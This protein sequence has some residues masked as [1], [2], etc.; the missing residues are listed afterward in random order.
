[1]EEKKLNEQLVAMYNLGFKDGL[2]DRTNNFNGDL[3]GTAYVLGKLDAIVGDD[4]PSLDLQTEEE[5]LHKI[6]NFNPR[7]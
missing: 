2:D 7:A 6:K 4:I 1:M 3:F 5:I